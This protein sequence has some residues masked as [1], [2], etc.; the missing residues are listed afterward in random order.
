MTIAILDYGAGNIKSVSKALDFLGTEHKITDSPKEIAK[1]DKL[2][3]PGVGNFGDVMT[4]LTKKKLIEPIR[5][6][7][8]SGKPYLGICLGLQILYDSSEESP[9]INGFKILKGNVR[10]LKTEL[11]V[12]HIGWNTIKFR[13]KSKLFNRIS[14]DNYFYFVHSYHVNPEDNGSI[15]TTT[16]YGMEFVSGIEQG[17]VYAVQFHPEKSSRLGLRLIENFLLI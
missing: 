7:I 11:K 2:I 9:G 14:N 4:L 17:N 3:F 10:M 1:C 15:L 16:D 5:L 8:S 6:F 13:K 12:P